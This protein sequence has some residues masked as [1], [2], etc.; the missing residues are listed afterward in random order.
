MELMAEP[1]VLLGAD[2]GAIVRSSSC[3]KKPWF[4]GCEHQSNSEYRV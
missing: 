4:R 3:K 2:I 1:L